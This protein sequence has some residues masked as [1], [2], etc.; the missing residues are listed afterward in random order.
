[1]V[2]AEHA[3]LL[4]LGLLIG[5]GCALLGILPTLRTSARS[6]NLPA[7]AA[8]LAAVLLIG[9]LGLS[10]AVWVGQR[11]ITVADLRAE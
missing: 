9:L 1:L 10:V 3:F 2:L 11:K 7:L 5:A 4:I 8:T 6:L